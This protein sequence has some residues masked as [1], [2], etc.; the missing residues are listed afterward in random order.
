MRSASQGHSWGYDCATVA[1][2]VLDT[3]A[4]GAVADAGVAAIVFRAPFSFDAVPGNAGKQCCAD[5]GR[6]SRG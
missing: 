6:C 2:S 3:D 4:A 5:N 1:L